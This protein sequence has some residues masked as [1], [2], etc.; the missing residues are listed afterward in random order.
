MILPNLYDIGRDA[1]INNNKLEV[2]IASKLEKINDNIKLDIL[3][4]ETESKKKLLV[5]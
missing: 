3:R 1:L 5:K 4:K 2:V